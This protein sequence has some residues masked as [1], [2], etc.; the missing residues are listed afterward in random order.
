[1]GWFTEELHP[2]LLSLTDRQRE[3]ILLRYV[4]DWTIEEIGQRFGIRHQVVSRHLK[5]A[6]IKLRGIVKTIAA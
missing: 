1:M 6:Q 2:A 5:A 3:C 4:E